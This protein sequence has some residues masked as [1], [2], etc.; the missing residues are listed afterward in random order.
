MVPG[1]MRLT[2]LP[3]IYAR[4]RF[5]KQ[6]AITGLTGLMLPGLL[7]ACGNSQAED[8][9][10]SE[11]ESA[12]CE[13]SDALSIADNATRQAVNYVDQAPDPEKVCANCRF[14]KSAEANAD[15]GTCDVVKGAIAQVG[16]CSAWVAQETA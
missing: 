8:Q 2:H 14:F 12:A 9:T 15:C 3:T 7:A 4:R 16:Y 1:N 13:S 10:S 11:A 5:L 6:A